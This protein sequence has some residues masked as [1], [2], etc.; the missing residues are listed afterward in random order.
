MYLF[1]QFDMYDTTAIIKLYIP[2]CIYFYPV[3]IVICT[4]PFAF[5]FHNVSISTRMCCSNVPLRLPLHSTM[6]LFLHLLLSHSFL[7]FSPLHS[8]MYLF[9]RD[10]LNAISVSIRSLHSTMYLFLL[11]GIWWGIRYDDLYIPQCIYFYALTGTD[12]C[13]KSFLYIP[14]CIYFYSFPHLLV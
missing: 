7:C 8:T 4:F 14:H 3:P 10:L 6:Y 11:T 13:F 1:L 9:L 12:T 2:Q 5:T